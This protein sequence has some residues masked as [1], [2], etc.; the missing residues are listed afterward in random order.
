MGTIAVARCTD[1]IDVMEENKKDI[2]E[3]VMKSYYDIDKGKGREYKDFFAELE[4]RY[5]NV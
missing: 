1:L 3:L 2:R 4:S 5:K